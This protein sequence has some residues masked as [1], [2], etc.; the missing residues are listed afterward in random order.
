[1]FDKCIDLGKS[2]S[3]T[4]RDQTQH[5]VKT[6]IPS[7]RA[8]LKEIPSHRAPLKEKDRKQFSRSCSGSSGGD[9]QE[10]HSSSQSR[11]TSQ[12]KIVHNI[13]RKPLSRLNS[14]HSFNR[15]PP[16]GHYTPYRRYTDDRRAQFRL[17]QSAEDAAS[18]GV[19][20]WDSD[21]SDIY[22]RLSVTT[23]DDVIRK[24]HVMLTQ[25]HVTNDYYYPEGEDVASPTFRRR[26]CTMPST[27]RTFV[28]PCI[29]I[30][31]GVMREHSSNF[32]ADG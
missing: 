17:Y 7:Y 16:G 15:V 11:S 26:V 1:M 8:P 27:P 3:T 2:P 28:A 25:Q 14:N 5:H 24:R 30:L 23:A 9:S 31:L 4:T 19:K 21:P 18:D 10:L 12:T 22:G 6:Q 29:R 13:Y 20:Q 32:P